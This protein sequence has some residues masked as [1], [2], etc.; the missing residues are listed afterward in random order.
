M[1]KN[2]IILISIIIISSILAYYYFNEQEIQEYRADDIVQQQT[3]MV[4]KEEIVIHISGEVNNPGVI[5]MEEGSR[6]ADAIEKAGGCTQTANLDNVN[7]AYIVQDGTKIYIPTIEEENNN[8][9]ETSEGYG[10][11]VDGKENMKININTASVVELQKI[12]GV[13][14]S[15]AQKIKDYR[16]KN[17][18]FTNIEE[19]K[20]VSGI[21][22]AKFA[23]MEEYICIK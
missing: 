13:G 9:L 4:E 11:I 20:N 6:I 23:N 1:T 21:G 17:G 5:K 3:E 22:E 19:L 16:E 2:K 14:E 12:P 15:T 18:R 8:I 7:L 10:V